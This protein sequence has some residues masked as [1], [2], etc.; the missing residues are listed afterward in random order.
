LPTLSLVIPAYDEEARLPA[1][2]ETLKETAAEAVAAAG[3]ELVEALVVDD[4]SGDRTAEIGRA[5][6]RAHPEIAM[7]VLR[8]EYNQGYGGNQKVG[9]AY[10]AAE[11]YDYVAMVHGDG[12]YAPEE[13]PRLMAPLIEGRADAVFA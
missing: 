7:T 13:L 9:Y 1:L 3:F 10:A 8:N 12:Q 4:G 2:L 6:R 11:G 5:Y